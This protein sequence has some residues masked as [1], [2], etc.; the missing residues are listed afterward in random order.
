MLLKLLLT[1]ILNRLHKL[2]SQP[3]MYKGKKYRYQ[4]IKQKEQYKLKIQKIRQ[5]HEIRR[6]KRQDNLNLY[7]KQK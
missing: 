1:Q 7:E 4:A 6:H 5:S 2:E 3:L